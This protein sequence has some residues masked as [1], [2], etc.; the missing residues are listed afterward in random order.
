MSEMLVAASIVMFSIS[1]IMMG[2]VK[3][4]VIVNIVWK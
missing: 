1:V 4:S 3:Q 2:K